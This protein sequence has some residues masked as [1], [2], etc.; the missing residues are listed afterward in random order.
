MDE[1]KLNWEDLSPI[2]KEMAVSNYAS[3]RTIED[4]KECS[5]ERALEDTPWC[6]AFYKISGAIEVD[7]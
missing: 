2:E 6:R 1:T 3:V 4:E 7:I 5:R